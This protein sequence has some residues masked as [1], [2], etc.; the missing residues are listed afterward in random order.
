MLHSAEGG[1]VP[2]NVIII[3]GGIA[4]LAAAANLRTGSVTLLEAKE[5][6]GGRVYTRH[7]A[8][9]V[10]ELGAEFLHG[11]DPALFHLIRNAHLGT[12]LVSD[13][14]R[15]FDKGQFKSV[16]VWNTFSEL[17]ER[18]DLRSKDSSFLEF[19]NQQELDEQTHR[20]MIA[21]A[22]G[23][24]AARADKLSAHGLRKAEYSAEQMEGAK[25][26]R[27]REG[28]TALVDFLVSAAQKNGATLLRGVTVQRIDWRKGGV[29]VQAI[30]G[31][32]P[33]E[34]MADAAIVTLPLG[35]LKARSVT[36]HPSLPE[37]EEAINGLEF[38]QVRKITLEFKRPWWPEPDFGFIHALDEQ[39]PTWW[40]HPAK[41]MITGW[42]GGPKAAALSQH[43][44]AQIEELALEI[45]A[46]VFSKKAD[47][48]RV[49]L[50]SSYSV[51]WATDPHVR[52]AYSYIPVGGIYLPKQLGAAVDNTLFFAGEATAQDAQMGTV[53]GALNSG[54]RVARE[55]STSL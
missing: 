29:H 26:M 1:G 22:E 6:L 53:F 31:D 23:F 51:D 42:A 17:T 10:V 32:Q 47:G 5:R 50:N 28:Y 19:I 54:L 7:A 39:I 33:E 4:G 8:D 34:Y 36:F 18:I 14:N 48:L 55:V 11:Q 41:P 35:V 43:N 3:G 52:G 27:L 30:R 40:S 9:G 46:R 37:K 25:Q 49:E 38:G 24:N 12:E 45:L 13:Q 44:S 21:F 2:G 15:V 16:D 20:T